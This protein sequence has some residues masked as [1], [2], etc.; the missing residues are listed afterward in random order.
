MAEMEKYNTKMREIAIAGSTEEKIAAYD[1]GVK[2]TMSNLEMLL[3]TLR[4][5]P[6]I[7]DKKDA[8]TPDVVRYTNLS[9]VIMELSKTKQEEA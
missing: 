7:Y 6:L 1:I 8:D 9:T 2:N 5:T 3:D 4:G